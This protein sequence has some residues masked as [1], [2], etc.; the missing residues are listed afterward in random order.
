MVTA[1]VWGPGGE[2]EGTAA[3]S[4]QPGAGRCSLPI[5][6]FCC[7]PVTPQ[8]HLPNLSPQSLSRV[9]NPGRHQLKWCRMA[10]MSPCVTAVAILGWRVA[11]VRAHRQKAVCAG[12]GMRYCPMGSRRSPTKPRRPHTAPGPG[13]AASPASGPRA[14]PGRAGMGAPPLRGAAGRGNGGA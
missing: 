14:P 13:S 12:T 1:P 8:G 9:Q 11:C 10:V 3:A 5:K 6:S 2:A 7:C 4:M